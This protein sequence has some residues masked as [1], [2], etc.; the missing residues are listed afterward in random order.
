MQRL[1]GDADPTMC[2][3]DYFKTIYSLDD[4]ARHVEQAEKH[5]YVS[6]WR[7]LQIDLGSFRIT[8]RMLNECIAKLKKGKGS[9]DGIT[10]EMF[11]ALPAVALN[12]LRAFLNY[13]FRSLDI[14]ADW[15]HISASLVP[16]VVGASSL[17]KFRPIASLPTVRKLFGY[18]WMRTLPP[19]TF[20][21]FQTGFVAKRQ[22]A[23]GVYVLKRAAE[24]QQRMGRESSCFSTRSLKGL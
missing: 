5:R 3:N 1:F 13:T 6:L 20:F 23:D 7:S 2:L 17:S 9:C 24:A 4:D 12:K 16:K 8:E 10:A 15:S 22:A 21:S 18:L 19:L 11:A 14:Q